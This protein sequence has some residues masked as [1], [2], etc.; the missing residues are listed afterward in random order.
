MILD[1]DKLYL[2]FP[3]GILALLSGSLVAIMLSLL[4]LSYCLLTQEEYNDLEEDE[5]DH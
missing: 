1:L 2:A 5:E 3:L 4:L